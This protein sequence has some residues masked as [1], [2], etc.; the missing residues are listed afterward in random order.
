MYVLEKKG[1]KIMF[2][3]TKLKRNK[4]TK[5]IKFFEKLKSLTPSQVNYLKDYLER[6]KE[7]KGNID[8]IER[9]ET[10]LNKPHIKDPIMDRKVDLK[11]IIANI[12]PPDSHKDDK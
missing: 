3:I 12:Y 10:I 11:K 8:L 2:K 6:V 5:S 7:S 1:G 4:L 9:I